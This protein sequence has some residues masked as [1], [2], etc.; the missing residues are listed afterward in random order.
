[1]AWSA[2]GVAGQGRPPGGGKPPVGAITVTPQ[3]DLSFGD[4]VPGAPATVYVDEVAAR[5]EWLIQS[6]GPVSV[7]LIL[8][9]E[10]TGPSGLQIPLSFAYGDAGYMEGG[11]VEMTLHDPTAGF[12][13]MVPAN[14][15][16][17]RVFLGGRALP[18][19]D[20]PPGTYT[21]TITIIVAR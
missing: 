12:Q 6:Q 20:L 3:Q 14:P 17:G 11:S 18:T 9:G 5:A 10:L 15:G 4:L 1:M 13:V 19:A 7:S 2:E 16:F 21:A 8:P